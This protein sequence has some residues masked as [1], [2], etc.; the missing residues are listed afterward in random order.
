MPLSVS[1]QSLFCP[2]V[3]RQQA[4]IPAHRDG[5]LVIREKPHIV[6]SP[7]VLLEGR[8]HLARLQLPHAD[9]SLRAAGDYEANVAGELDRRSSALVSIVDVPQVLPHVAI[10]A[11]KAAVG[12]SGHDNVLRTTRRQG[13]GAPW[14]AH[15]ASELRRVV[16]GVPERYETIPGAGEEVIRDTRQV[17]HIIQS[18]RRN[19]AVRPN[20]QVLGSYQVG[21]AQGRHS[22]NLRSVRRQREGR[23]WPVE[24]NL[25]LL[26]QVQRRGPGN[27]SDS[28]VAAHHYEACSTC[29]GCAHKVCYTTAAD[30]QEVL[31]HSVFHEDHR[32]IT[33]GGPCEEIFIILRVG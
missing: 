6:H 22:Q 3:P 28:A 19:L 13:M 32:D 17:G 33:R 30:C 25:S 31:H 23:Q 10:P 20:G 12:S 29:H 2:Q 18:S 8:N 27:D 1:C 11:E 9:F 5:V 15:A 4:P 7:A 26:P 16:V 24:P 14:S 21:S